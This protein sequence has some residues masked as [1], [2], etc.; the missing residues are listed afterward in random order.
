MGY[1]RAGFDVV[2]VDINPQPHYPFEFHQA[3]ALEYCAAHGHEFDVIHAS[4]PCQAYSRTQSL[5][6]AAGN[7]PDLVYVMRQLLIATGRPYVIENVPGAPLDNPLMLCGTMF[8][9]HVLRHRLFECNP[10]IW[11][12]P[13]TC[14]HDGLAFPMFW[15]SSRQI[16]E[17]PVRFKYKFI[18]VAGRSFR[19]SQ[20][21]PAMGI[22]WMTARE[23]AQA[24]PP[25]Y[26][27]YI[28]EQ[29]LSDKSINL[30][31]MRENL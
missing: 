23:I 2:G 3:D 7:H 6:N 24:I 15:K 22:D 10:P 13:A 5:P 11:W 26:T 31:V 29:F 12:P 21:A 20:A 14:A 1:H 25:A 30:E 4:P 18:T 28:G 9:L 27:M 19:M 16:E 17:S 8:R